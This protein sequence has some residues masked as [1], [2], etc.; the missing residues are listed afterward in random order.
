MQ[1]IAI[2]APSGLELGESSRSLVINFT[3]TEHVIHQQQ[4]ACGQTRVVVVDCCVYRLS[5][6]DDD[7]ALT[8]AKEEEEPQNYSKKAKN[9]SH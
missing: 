5:A 8:R 3:I 2:Y 7:D 1:Q 9:R 4:A 6:N